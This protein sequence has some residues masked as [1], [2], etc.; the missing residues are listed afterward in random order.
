MQK[1]WRTIS[2]AAIAAN[3]GAVVGMSKHAVEVMHQNLTHEDSFSV[4]WPRYIIPA[5]S[6]GRDLDEINKRSIDIIAAES[7]RLRAQGKTTVDLFVWSRS[8]ILK[9]TT[10]AIY[11]PHNPYRDAAVT[12]A[13]K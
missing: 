3:A 6:P 12:D 7:L 11:G 8:A 10:E 9:S 13:W 2:F 5:M 4:S 1:N